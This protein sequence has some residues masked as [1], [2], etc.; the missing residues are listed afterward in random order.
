MTASRARR[1]FT[2]HSSSGF[3]QR[4]RPPG[5]PIRTQE[6]HLVDLDCEQALS[7]V[8]NVTAGVSAPNV[9]QLPVPPLPR[10]NRVHVSCRLAPA[11]DTGGRRAC[12]TLSAFSTKPYQDFP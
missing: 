10:E 4:P 7:K 5:G 1:E 9:M 2:S 3:L 8:A 12:S 11:C 6:W